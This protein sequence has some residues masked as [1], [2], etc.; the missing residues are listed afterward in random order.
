MERRK[1]IERERRKSETGLVWKNK[2]H[3]EMMKKKR[4]KVPTKGAKPVWQWQAFKI[5]SLSR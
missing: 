2:F 4:S 3:N 5:S 1:K